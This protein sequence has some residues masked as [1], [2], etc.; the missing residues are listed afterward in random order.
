MVGF[1]QSPGQQGRLIVAAFSKLAGV[2]WHRQ[3][4]VTGDRMVLLVNREEVAKL[5]GRRPNPS[6]FEGVNCVTNRTLE[7][8]GTS[9]AVGIQGPFFAPPAGRLVPGNAATPAIWAG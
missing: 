7:K 1:G 9:N 8:K 6:V 2:Q 4:D 3:D 5:G